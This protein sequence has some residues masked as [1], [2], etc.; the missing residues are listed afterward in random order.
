M[1]E[2]LR[3]ELT[4]EA[5]SVVFDNNKF[6][7]YTA[8]DWYPSDYPTSV[9]SF[10]AYVPTDSVDLPDAKKIEIS[11]QSYA[12]VFNQDLN[13]FR[14]IYGQFG[15]PFD[16]RFGKIALPEYQDIT[17]V[18]S[19]LDIREVMR[20]H[21]AVG[22]TMSRLLAVLGME[23][24]YSSVR[25]GGSWLLNP[26]NVNRYDIDIKFGGYAKASLA[27]QRINQAYKDG[28]ITKFSN[29][30]N[31][32]FKFEETIFDPQFSL[33]ATDYN[34]FAGFV[35]GDSLPDISATTEFTILSTYRSIFFPIIYGTDKGPLISF[36][37]GQRGLFKE[38]Q[39]IVFDK[40]IP[41]CDMTFSKK[42]PQV[43]YLV[44]EDQYAGT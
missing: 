19:P 16:D 36:R 1:I 6:L 9:P 25:V 17:L 43:C 10:L 23:N 3:D 13:T 30:F 29:R 12:K 14:E 28:N 35:I 37:P 5:G 24:Q 27:W 11:G 40:P 41:A 33:S 2:G 38:G 22:H 7:Y 42:N 44:G 4:P 26:N 15:I 21:P 39:K 8:G 18:C 31:L 34:P 32:P 20:T